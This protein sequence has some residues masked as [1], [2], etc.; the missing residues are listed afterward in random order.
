M[1]FRLLVNVGLLTLGY[2]VGRKV[3]RMQVQLEG[4]IRPSR[5]PPASRAR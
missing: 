2:Y 5:L 1:M 4:R 3:C